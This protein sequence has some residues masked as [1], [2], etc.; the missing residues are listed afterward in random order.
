MS[1]HYYCW[2]L[3]Y[4][5]DQEFD[6]ALRVVCDEVRSKRGHWCHIMYGQVLGPLVFNTVKARAEELGGSALMLTEFGTCS[7][8]ITHPDYQGEGVGHK[9]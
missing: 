9:T 7:P 6:P 4:S 2:A 3:G 1:W 8:D 5:S